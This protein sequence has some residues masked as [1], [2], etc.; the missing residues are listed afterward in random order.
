MGW[1]RSWDL[2][3]GA[4]GD[5]G[6]RG[7]DRVAVDVEVLDLRRFVGSLLAH[8]RLPGLA[9]EARSYSPGRR[10]ATAIRD[11]SSVAAPGRRSRSSGMLT[12]SAGTVP[13]RPARAAN[14]R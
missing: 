1:V 4:V 13:R 6:R 12:R 8:R 3:L 11:A 2:P 5:Y 7:G 9:V 10:L 14:A